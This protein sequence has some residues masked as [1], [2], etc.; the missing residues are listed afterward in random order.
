MLTDQH[1]ANA[2]TAAELAE[3][4]ETGYLTVPGA[5][6]TPTIDALEADVDAIYLE[7]L[8]SGYDPYRKSPLEPTAAFFYPNFLWRSPRFIHLLDHPLTFPK[9]WGILG[10]NIYCFHSH[11]IVTPPRDTRARGTGRTFFHQD[12]GRVNFDLEVHPRPRLSVKVVFWLSDCSEPG[13]ANLYVVPGSQRNDLLE[14]PEDGSLPDGAIPV[15]GKP[16]DAVIF[17]RRLWHSSSPNDSDVTR[18]G[19]F[20]GYGYRWLRPKDDMTISEEQMARQDPIRRQLLGD[21]SDNN[22]RFTPL[23]EDTPLKT[24]LESSG[25]LQDIG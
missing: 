5:L 16:G 1:A 9:V 20:L 15:C 10:W 24:W 22:H 25:L 2:I 14:R 11:L 17:D 8:D 7:H 21:S 18:K 4:E 23:P 19:L 3:F 12:S 13:R 6:D